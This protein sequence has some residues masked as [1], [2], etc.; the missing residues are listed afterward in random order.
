MLGL[1]F[2]A[3]KAFLLKMAGQNHQPSSFNNVGNLYA[4]IEQK[5][6]DD[7]IRRF[8]DMAGSLPVLIF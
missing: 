4:T 5:R 7:Q 2:V 3:K 1:K 8:C 6:D